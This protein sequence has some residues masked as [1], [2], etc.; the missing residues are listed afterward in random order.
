MRH[1]FSETQKKKSL[2]YFGDARVAGHQ[3][4]RCCSSCGSFWVGLP[5]L[6]DH[7]SV[8]S[9]VLCTMKL[10]DLQ[11]LGW[12]CQSQSGGH[13]LSRPSIARIW[14]WR[15]KLSSSRFG[16]G[17]QTALFV[18][19]YHPKILW[20]FFLAKKPGWK[21]EDPTTLQPRICCAAVASE[22]RKC[23][24]PG[25]MLLCWWFP[26]SIDNVHIQWLNQW[27]K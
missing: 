20:D 21:L 18:I 1:L 19:I 15:V 14:G 25:R 27:S 5:C 16:R 23:L 17:L 3:Q 24:E 12:R 13:C 22:V 9:T 26:A 4:D 8:V 6:S 7:A 2:K 11:V 10:A